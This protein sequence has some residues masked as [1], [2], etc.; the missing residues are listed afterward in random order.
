MAIEHLIKGYSAQRQ[1]A[2]FTDKQSKILNTTMAS[3]ICLEK[4]RLVPAV[5]AIDI[6]NANYAPLQEGGVSRSQIH[7]WP[8]LLQAAPM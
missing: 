6:I 7:C 2:Q 5:M 8:L 4:P 3:C 1:K